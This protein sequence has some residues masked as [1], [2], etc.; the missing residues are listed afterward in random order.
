MALR[1]LFVCSGNICRSPLAEYLARD[2]WKEAD[3][4]TA[5]AGTFA[6][7]GEPATPLMIQMGREQGVELTPHS[8]TPLNEADEPDVVFGMER[9]HI[10]AARARFPN[11]PSDHIMLLG[12]PGIDDPYGLGEVAYRRSADIIAAALDAVD[13]TPYLERTER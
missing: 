10:E 4:T 13:L 9:H 5:S 11:L 12:A 6:R 1:I 2:R 3:I 7:R 8:A